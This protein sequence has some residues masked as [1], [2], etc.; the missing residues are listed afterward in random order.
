MGA[1]QSQPLPNEKLV[2]ERLRDLQLQDPEQ[3]QTD[4]FIHIDEKRTH[5]RAPWTSLS[6]DEIGDWEHALLQD[7][8]NRY[9]LGHGGRGGAVMNSPEP[10]P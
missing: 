4:D 1:N 3:T 6:A 8:K 10:E 2:I 9:V 7:P 5:F